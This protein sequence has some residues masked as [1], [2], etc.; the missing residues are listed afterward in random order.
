MR[1]IGTTVAVL[2]TAA[3]IASVATP[4]AAGGKKYFG[5]WKYDWSQVTIFN[6]G[7]P[8]VPYSPPTDTITYFG[9]CLNLAGYQQAG[10]A[11]ADGY[12]EPFESL[13]GNEGTPASPGTPGVPSSC[14]VTGDH[15]WKDSSHD[16]TFSYPGECITHS[17]NGGAG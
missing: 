10:N 17:H 5:F 6:P 7:T 3:I 11:D 16:I 14:S 2:A 9:T 13:V 15:K 12:C 8:A 1:N 4:A